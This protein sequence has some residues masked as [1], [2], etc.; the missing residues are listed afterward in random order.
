MNISDP[1]GDMI[2]RIRNAQMRGKA[3]VNTPNSKL[4]ANVL[5]VLI[6][7]GYIRSYYEVQ[8]GNHPELA[9]ELK[10]VSYTHLGVYKRQLQFSPKRIALDVRKCL[11]SA[12]ANAENNHNLDIDTLVVSCLLYTSRC[13]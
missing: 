3:V 9:I 2:T 1:I 11:Q 12:I 6:K 13:V 5:D 10:S 4:R 7:E 8:V